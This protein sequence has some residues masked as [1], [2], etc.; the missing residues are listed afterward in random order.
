MIAA[1]IV[2]NLVCIAIN[3]HVKHGGISGPPVVLGIGWNF[4]FISEQLF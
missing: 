4:M 3:L 2:L 1:G